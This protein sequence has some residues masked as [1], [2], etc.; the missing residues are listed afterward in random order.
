M[1]KFY[2][3][4]Q[5]VFLP[6]FFSFLFIPLL[7]PQT[8]PLPVTAQLPA[9][10]VSPSG[11]LERFNLLPV[12][13]EKTLLTAPVDQARLIGK[14]RRVQPVSSATPPLLPV[15][16]TIQRE[17]WER[18]NKYP[19]ATPASPGTPQ[20]FHGPAQSKQLKTTAGTDNPIGTPDTYAALSDQTLSIAAPGFLANDIDPEGE[21]LTVTALTDNVDHGNLQSF[22][23]GSFE[24]TPNPGFTGTD[25]FEYQ[26]EDDS[27]NL[28]DPVTVTLQVIL[29]NRNPVS[30]NDKYSA[31]ENTTLGISPPGFLANDIDPDG[32]VITVAAI[33]DDVDHGTL[34]PLADGSFS[35][36]PDPGFTGTDAFEYQ[37]QDASGNLSDPV[38]VT[39]E[40]LSGSGPVAV[41][42]TF[43]AL[44][45]QTLSIS[46]PGFLAND[47]DLDGESLTVTAIIDNVDH[48]S[49][50]AVADGSFEYT[51]NA[52]FLGTD[53][54][55][56]QMQ[57]A[58]GNLSDPVKV[59]LPVI[60]GNR[61]P[62]AV[63][64]EYTALENTTLSITAPGFLANDIDPDGE[65]ITVTAITDA[66][67]HGAFSAQADGSFSYTPNAGFTGTD[68]FE[69]QMEDDSGNLSD[70]VTVT[71][72]VIKGNRD[73]VGIADEYAAIENT[74]L[75]ITAPGF[76]ANDIDPDGETITV[77][78]ITDAADHGAFSA[79]ADGSFSYTPNAGFTGSDAFVYQMQDNSGN[80]SGEITVEI[81]V[82]L[83]NEPPAA[84][85]GDDRTVECTSTSGA[86]VTLDASASSDP[87]GDEL[88]F[89]WRKK[90]NIIA[91]PTTD[92]QVTVVLSLGSHTIELTVEDEHGATD[93]DEVVITVEDTTAPALSC[94]API[95]IA[96]DEPI[97]PSN[98]GMATAEDLCDASPSLSFTDT[99]EPGAC[100]Q[101]K[102]ITRT[103]TATDD[104][105]N[106]NSCTQTIEVIDN[107]PPAGTCPNL[108]QTVSC[109]EDI[110]C[111]G[112]SE[113]EAFR[114]DI[115]Q[116]FS[117][118]CGEVLVTLID[119]SGL[120]QCGDA[121]VGEF[122]RSYFFEVADPCGN[123]ADI[124]TVTFSG[125]C[126]PFCTL[127]Q[128]GWGNAGGN[129]P[130]QGGVASTTSI[131]SSL[132]GVNGP[133][134]IGRPGR[135]LT[136]QSPQCVFELLPG[137]GSPQPLKAGNAI[138]SP[139]RCD[140]GSNRQH[141]QGRL[142][143][144]LATQTI[145]LQ[146]NAWY[147]AASGEDLLAYN[148]ADG[149]VD[150][151]IDLATTGVGYPTTIQGL[152]D[153]A[154]DVLGG[155]Y[156][157]KKKDYGNLAGQATEAISAV[158]EYWNECEVADPCSAPAT[159]AAEKASPEMSVRKTLAAEGEM[160]LYPNPASGQIELSF[161]GKQEEQ[162]LIRLI[163]LDGKAHLTSVFQAAE[164]INR[165]TLNLSGLPSG[166]YWVYLQ[167]G[168]SVRTQKVVITR[169]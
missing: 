126:A 55:E 79:Q 8:T 16:E 60:L 149:C 136:V 31:L 168:D 67:D 19:N 89:T 116:A 47:I 38:K 39:L 48:G 159:L 25:S 5:R 114:Q 88:T 68:A 95:T 161:S 91:G 74:T 61:P 52:G 96:C 109:V 1:K 112:S 14:L 145:A 23:D 155:A 3:L 51:P 26:M 128:G 140:A 28:S 103:W 11:S 133:V 157:T 6:V 15:G 156:G 36:T 132:M 90:G 29:G 81:I 53:A 86:A 92:E 54:F 64:D 18:K 120:Q 72:Q 59:T 2:P 144:N 141:R 69:Y 49:L 152:L 40:V 9:K 169:E 73:P 104:S 119:D 125:S 66:A 146:L 4:G 129:Y 33:T 50:L 17:K 77:T 102:T 24:Y 131:I 163:G 75:S 46:A 143:N 87:D 113:L 151:G 135:Q 118:N 32:E 44:S 27:G 138:A 83:I 42:D 84:Q 142:K 123:V 100:P 7:I 154:N 127:T 153:L 99:V 98:T 111:V 43:A 20:I 107:T 110:P 124:C 160:K 65:T 80:L 139:P 130:W 164:G 158:N 108:N 58:S 165:R 63:A 82:Y 115:G 167:L 76:L 117:D 10:Q 97:A 30:V 85:T 93:T 150:I 134:T 101:E 122:S 22:A 147:N 13:A 121:P 21:A 56:Y 57:D 45:D 94:P 37:M 34:N 41:P 70:P 105:G 166:L 137:A 78:A 106:S 35:Y 62:V 162:A 12:T 148:L 71:L